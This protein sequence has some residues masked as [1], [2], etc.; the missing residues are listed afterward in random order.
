[1]I[2]L[3]LLGVGAAWAFAG[4]RQPAAATSAPKPLP[5]ESRGSAE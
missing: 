1:M 3:Y 5:S 2:A 4:E